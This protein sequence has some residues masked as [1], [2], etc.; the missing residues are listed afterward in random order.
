MDIVYS[1]EGVPIR[2]TTERWLHIV[3]NHDDMAGYYDDVLTTVEDPE[4]VLLGHKGSLVAVQNYGRNRYL[5]VI[6]RQVS[7]EDG[8]VITAFFTEEI[9]RGNVLWKRQ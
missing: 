4:C 8:F 3:E 5:M 2:L 6:Y 7:R 1:V 9:D